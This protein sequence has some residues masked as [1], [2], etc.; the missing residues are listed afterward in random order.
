MSTN[1]YELDSHGRGESHHPTSPP[2]AVISPTSVEEIQDILRSCLREKHERG[3]DVP[4]VEIVS[5]IPYGAGTSLEGH[6]QFLYPDDGGGTENHGSE[7]GKIVEVPSSYF[8]NH[9]GK[10]NSYRKVRIKRMG[11]I[12]IDMCNFQS[13]G[14]VGD[15]FVTVGAGV[16]RNTLN[17]E[18]R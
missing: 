9:G 18:L 16:T 2:D 4:T 3:D 15:G 1:H 14:E 7:N 13:I 6:L 10:V 12:S 5:I 17:Q 11:G 8:A